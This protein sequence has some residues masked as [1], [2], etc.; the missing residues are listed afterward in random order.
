MNTFMEKV[1][2]ASGLLIFAG[3]MIALGIYCMQILN[4]SVFSILFSS[5]FF[6]GSMIFI[7]LIFHE[8]KSNKY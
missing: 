5:G 7:A 2:I 8:F 6:I 4:Y 3:L 1:E